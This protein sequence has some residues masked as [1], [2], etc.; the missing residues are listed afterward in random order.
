MC[1]WMKPILVWQGWW[2]G[3]AQNNKDKRFWGDI[4]GMIYMERDRYLITG[5]GPE[6]FSYYHSVY[7]NA[8]GVVIEYA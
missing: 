5:F 7:I 4:G 2:R 8:I 3:Y 1:T 6:L